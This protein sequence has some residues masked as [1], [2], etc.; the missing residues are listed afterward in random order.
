MIVIKT[1]SYQIKAQNIDIKKIF[2]VFG[3]SSSRSECRDLHRW[4]SRGRKIPAGWS[5]NWLPL[6]SSATSSAVKPAA[7]F[8][9]PKKNSDA[10]GV[11][12]NVRE[13]VRVEGGTVAQ[14]SAGRGDAVYCV[15]GGTLSRLPRSRTRSCPVI[16]TGSS[17]SFQLQEGGT[18]RHTGQLIID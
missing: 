1:I 10:A 15:G 7:S 14:S 13:E 5:L 9:P 16:L 12:M 3:L 2:V 17:H 4:D 18:H 8:P 11:L 6:S